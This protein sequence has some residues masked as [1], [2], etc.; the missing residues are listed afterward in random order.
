M[1]GHI[2]INGQIGSDSMTRG[3]ELQD[4]IIQVENN[5]KATSLHFHVKGQGGSVRVGDLI[6]DYIETLPNAYTIAEGVASIS[7]RICLAVP[8]ERRS[9]LADTEY[10]I[11][12][13]LFQGING[14]AEELRYAADQ[15]DPVQEELLSMYHKSTG[16]A[17]AALEGLMRQETSL[18]DEQCVTL[19][20][21][22]KVD[23]RTELQAVAF[24]DNETK[25]KINM[26]TIKEQI[27][28]GFDAIKAEF[29]TKEV[30]AMVVS[31]DKGELSYASEGETPLVDEVVTIEGEPAAEGNYMIANGMVIVVG[32]EGLVM[33]IV[34][35]E[36]VNEE[37]EALKLEIEALKISA[38]AKDEEFKA[39]LSLQTEAF[40]TE[41]TEFKATVGSSFEP[42]A[43]K[44]EFNPAKNVLTGKAA[45]DERREQIKN[46]KNKK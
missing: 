41:L 40:K 18:T 23:E 2:Y 44:K 16:L 20:F 15:L 3:V 42:K 33:E 26:S 24:L 37:V 12:N 8:I 6:A 11:H 9:I 31:T 45:M 29:M 1:I 17:K 25:T 19:G 10:F 35:P 39:E 21:A 38:A 14:N 7:T 27:R 32:A 46:N 36:E 34:Q 22:S 4:V 5:K 28:E 13:P 30:K 43:E